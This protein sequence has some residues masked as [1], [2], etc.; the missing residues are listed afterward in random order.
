MN[1]DFG[2][3]DPLRTSSENTDFSLSEFLPILRRQ[4]LTA[5]AVAVTVFG[6]IAWSTLK[7][8][9]QYQSQ[10]LILLNRKATAPIVPDESAQE[11]VT[12]KQD[13][14]TEIQIL[15]SYALVKRALGNLLSTA[16][17]PQ[18][19]NSSNSAQ[20]T[21]DDIIAEAIEN[22]S[23]RQAGDADVLI[24]S[25][26]DPKPQ[27]TK[28]VLDVL[29]KTYV[30]YS[31]E[32]Q[33]S[34]ATN[35][36]Q[37][38]QA[39]LDPARAELDAAAVAVREF[40]QR[41]GIVDP[42]V[43][44]ADVS[45]TKQELEKQ[46]QEADAALSRT[47]RQYTELRRQAIEAG[48]NPDTALPKAL[49]GED[50]VYQQLAQQFKEL[51]AKYALERTRFHDTHPVVEDLRLQVEEMRQMLQNRQQQVLGGAASGAID[52]VATS[53]ETQQALAERLVQAETELAAQESQLQAIQR[54]QADVAL[55]FQQ[56]PQLQQAYAELQR[57]LEV[58][59][60]SVNQFLERLQE[61]QIA[62]AQEIAPWQILE[63][64]YVPNVP[65][66]PNIKRGL[67]LGLIAG[68]LL[69]IGAAL[70]LEQ[71]D[72]RVKQ[73]EEVK[74]LTRLPLLG[75]VP[76][77]RNPAIQIETDSYNEQLSS[78]T[79]ALRSLAMNLR[80]LVSETGKMK[81][82]AITSA[83]PSE[84]K[85]TL[86]YNLSWV[87]SELGMRVLVVDAD[88]RRPTIHK[89]AHLS[90]AVG[91]STA[92]AT[93]RPWSQLVRPGETEN[94]EILTAG[95]APPNPVALLDSKLM[96]NLLAEWREAYDY[97][98]IDTPPIATLADAQ[99]LSNRVDSAILV[100]G[101][102]RASRDALHR[103]IES[104][105]GCDV[106][107][108]VA[109]LTNKSHG[110]YAYTA[111]SYYTSKPIYESEALVKTEGKVWKFFEGFRRH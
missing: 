23:I 44:A 13:L 94:L 35:A 9:P 78:F 41:Y 82:L 88:M 80:Y 24:V 110:S 85:S 18:P 46:A 22:L 43:Y 54:A 111:R 96:Q 36:I 55:N 89:L 31:L 29:G 95:P 102:E 38:I 21:A 4:W 64:P 45:K 50:S 28:A 63:P 72:R 48:Q 11:L 77:V 90:N 14:S 37:F 65:I 47:Q 103:A 70:M 49:L 109:N 1:H 74:R 71:L 59:S 104:L 16:D 19:Q 20:T 2:I 105:R 5:I 76:K 26:T 100:V 91:L 92:I 99:C 66:S 93:D 61:L 27:Q 3:S 81:V 67:V 68:G 32:R 86:T 42:D 57:K 106:A 6:A 101:M 87:L 8:T 53:G 58:K 62:E 7:Q 97:V 12:G 69:G 52:S 40:R 34:Q 79:E 25:Y 33:R 75:T 83:T 73:V 17:Q 30:E 98:L 60:K 51:D 39:Q 10:T 15:R 84:G 56:I 108:F 107:G